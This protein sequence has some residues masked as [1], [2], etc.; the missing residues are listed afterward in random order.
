[1]KALITG[2]NGQLGYELQQT[3]PEGVELFAYDSG[4]L[5]IRNQTAVETLVNE[6]KPNVIINAAAYTAVDKAESDEE[7]AYAVNRDGAK[8][9][10]EA[11]KSISAKL[12]HISTDFVF[13]ADKN[14]PYLPE[15]KTDPLGVYG[16]SK[17]DGELAIQEIY[18]DNSCIIRTSWVYSEHGNNF[19]K[20]ML[21]LM[22]EKPELGVVGDQIGS[23]TWANGLAKA[24][25]TAAMSKESGLYHYSDLGVASWY[26]FAVAIQEVGLELGQLNNEIPVKPIKITDYPTP[27]KRPAYSV[28]DTSKIRNELKI[29]G[30]HWRAALKQMMQS[31]V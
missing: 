23:P 7:T 29:D 6:L 14:S 16:A 24:C 19:V 1:M 3:S 22:K 26:D 25:W 8:F 18:P 30:M 31:L 12:I 27:A 11:A 15:D 9:L 5:D 2:K 10:A 21:R 17:L 13:N 28:M 4:E 20:T